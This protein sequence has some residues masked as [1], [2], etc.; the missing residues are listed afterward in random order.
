MRETMPRAVGWLIVIAAAIGLADVL[1]TFSHIHT[2]LMVAGLRIFNG[3]VF[4]AA[5][6]LALQ[7]A[8]RL[9]RRQKSTARTS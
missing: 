2:S 6:G 8:Y 9:L 7:L 4:G 3:L 1:D 5:I